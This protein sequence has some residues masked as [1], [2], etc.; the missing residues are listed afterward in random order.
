MEII[1]KNNKK[2]PAPNT[3]KEMSEYNPLSDFDTEIWENM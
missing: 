1:L 3:I 2:Q